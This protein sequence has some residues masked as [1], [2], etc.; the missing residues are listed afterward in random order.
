L[1]SSSSLDLLLFSSPVSFSLSKGHPFSGNP[2]ACSTGAKSHLFPGQKRSRTPGQRP[3]PPKGHGPGWPSPGAGL[4]RSSSAPPSASL[5]KNSPIPPSSSTANW[6]TRRAPGTSSE[7]YLIPVLAEPKKLVQALD[8]LRSLKSFP[9]P[10]AV[11][12]TTGP[13][14]PKYVSAAFGSLDTPWKPGHLRSA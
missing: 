10:K 13:Q 9:S 3:L 6:K 12:T 2:T 7:P 5:G 14:L 4:P 11:N 1:R 8:R